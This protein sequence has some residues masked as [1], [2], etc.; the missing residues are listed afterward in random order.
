MSKD[1]AQAGDKKPR[2]KMGA[3]TKYTDDLPEILLDFFDVPLDRDVVKECA[4]K[5]GAFNIIESKPCR[6]PTVEGF[7]AS[8]LISKVTFHKW[9]KKYPDLM[10]ALGVA[11]NMQMNHLMQHA[12]EGGYNGGFAKFLAQNISDYRDKIET[13]GTNETAITITIDKNDNE[14]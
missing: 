7:C 2:K 8:R 6:L 13:T 3:P 4:G 14:L 5:E 9:T 11:K 10:N 12:L 1:K